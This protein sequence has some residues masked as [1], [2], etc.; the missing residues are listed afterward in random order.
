[1]LDWNEPAI[2]F[3]RALG[4]VMLDEWTTHRLEGDALTALAQNSEE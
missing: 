1:M 2:A 3:Y 4:A